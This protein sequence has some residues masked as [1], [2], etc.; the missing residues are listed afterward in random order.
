MGFIGTLAVWRGADVEAN[1]VIP[2]VTE[3]FQE[4]GPW[5][6]SYLDAELIGEDAAPLLSDLCRLT[7]AP[8]LAAFVFESDSAFV[9]ALAPG[10]DPWITCLVRDAVAGLEGLDEAGMTVRYGSSEQGAERAIEWSQRAGLTPD[11]GAV[12]QV[13]AVKDSPEIFLGLRLF[14]RL[15]SALGLPEPEEKP[16][17]EGPA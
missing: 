10:G 7:E 11:A 5:V 1:A 13:L 14:D 6:V 4:R 17:Y 16:W 8:A 3:S 15:L 9:T 2:D 12:Q